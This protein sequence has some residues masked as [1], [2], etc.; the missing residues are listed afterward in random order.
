M[1]LGI[2]ALFRTRDMSMFKI[3]TGYDRTA[4]DYNDSYC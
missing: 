2:T 4:V 3:E 1:A